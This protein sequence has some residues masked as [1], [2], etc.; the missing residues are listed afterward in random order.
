[1]LS[2][3]SDAE[4]LAIQGAAPAKKRPDPPMFPGAMLIDQ[5]EE[6]AVL[7]VLRAKRL[8]RYYGPHSG[9]S[10]VDELERA[11]ATHMGARYALAVS[12]GTAALICGL[13]GIGVGPGDEVIVPAYTW[14]ASPA[15]V[16]AVGAVPVVAEVDTSL[17]LDPVDVERKITPYTKA[18]VAVHMRGAPCR[19]DRLLNIARSHDLGVIED[20][21]QSNGGRYKGQS[22]GSIGDVGCFSLQFRKIITSGEG[23]MVITDNECVWK[24]AFMFHDVIG[25]LRRNFPMDGILWGINFRMPELLAAVAGVQLGRL[26]ALLSAMRERKR[27]VKAGIEDTMRR[28][29]IAAR[30]LTDPEGDTGIS[31]VFFVEDAATA[32]RVQVALQAENVGASILYRPEET[33]YHVYPH[34]VPIIERR[35][36]TPHGGPWRWA[37]RDI[38][39]TPDMCP[40]TLDLLGRSIHLDISP[41]LTHEDVEGMVK[42]V[43]RVLSALA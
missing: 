15:S 35:T 32:R 40:R 24:R 31:L 6:R 37:R 19:M 41:W 9:P 10:K 23:G 39:Y 38:E 30:E 13:Q 11:F 14:I 20:T 25:G 16:L 28:K 3:E 17:T 26:E 1:M 34:W 27:E 4:A 5:E 21:A 18:I 22:L 8:F 12:S 36:W 42:G 2:Q 29:G 33:D 43:N 7:E